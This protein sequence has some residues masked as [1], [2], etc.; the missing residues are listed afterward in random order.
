MAG[1]C[2]FLG[3]HGYFLWNCRETMNPSASVTPV[4]GLAWD[5]STL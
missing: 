4:P 2:Y 5:I 1:C 3:V